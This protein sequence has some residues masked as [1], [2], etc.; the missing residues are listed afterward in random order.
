MPTADETVQAHDIDGMVDEDA[1][2]FDF[3][4]AERGRAAIRG[5]LWSTLNTLIPTILSALVFIVTSRYL[6][7]QDFGV[8]ALATSIVTFASGFGPNAFGEALIQRRS[9]RKSHVDTVFWLTFGAAALIYVVLLALSSFFTS[10]VQTDLT[11]LV[12]VIGLKL[13]FDMCAVVPTALINRIMAF[14][15]ATI[16]T[17]IATL[18]SCIVSLALIVAG[19]GFWAIALAQIAS[20]FA[21]C[22]AAFWGAGWIPGLRVRYSSLRELLHYGT[23]ASANRFLQTMNLDQLLIGSLV[24]PAALGLY[25]FARRMLQMLNGIVSGGLTSVTHV[26]LSSLQGDQQ[27]VRDAFLKATFG[28]SLV[29]LPVFL[30]LAAVAAD[31]IPVIFGAQWQGAVPSVRCFC[32]MGMMQGIGIIQASLIMSQ[33]KADWWFYYMLAKNIAGIL[34]VLIFYRWGIDAISLALLLQTLAFWPA[35][36]VMTSRIIGLQVT[37]YFGQFGRPLLAIALMGG[38]IGLVDR[39]APTSSHLVLLIIKVLLGGTVYGLM[40]LALCRNQILSL[41]QTLKA[42]RA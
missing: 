39:L 11:A 21:S 37:D 13:F 24:S 8:V 15:L 36:L 32:I 22:V 42:R 18:A 25:N 26:L 19:F 3:L 6:V 7:P 10:F 5:A 20:S 23:F 4:D 34:I 27:R 31:A 14:H 12:A 16:R 33:G 35:T 41:W 38:A 1:V 30:G 40:I 2:V 17:T 28:C 29:S 9:I